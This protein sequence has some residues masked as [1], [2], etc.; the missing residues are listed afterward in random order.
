MLFYWP[1][2]QAFAIK[3]HKDF[4]FLWNKPSWCPHLK[5][6]FRLIPQGIGNTLQGAANCVMFVLFTQPIRTRLC[7][8]LTS[9]SQCRA[10]AQ[11]PH[12]LLP[13][14][15]ATARREEDSTE[16][17]HADRWDFVWC[18]EKMKAKQR[19]WHEGRRSS[20]LHLEPS[21]HKVLVR[22][23]LEVL[24]EHALLCHV[25]ALWVMGCC[26]LILCY[27]HIRWSIICIYCS[28]GHMGKVFCLVFL[29]VG[30]CWWFHFPF[31]RK[32]RRSEGALLTM[33][34]TQVNTVKDFCCCL[35][36]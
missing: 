30:V 3:T 17:G 6:L 1:I 34:C 14:Q 12:R 20:L 26:C 21:L 31:Q 29:W 19:G 16:R 4:L 28:V 15:D 27:L 7:A 10:E 2:K 36:F 11:R 24:Q 13:E 33:Y 25:S 5:L 8:A 9:C 35:F 23:L 22:W 18:N 32:W